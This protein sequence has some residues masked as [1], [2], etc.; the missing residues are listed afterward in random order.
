MQGI[1][2]SVGLIKRDNKTR[3]SI[4]NHADFPVWA[5][6]AI[7]LFDERGKDKNF[8]C[9]ILFSGIKNFPVFS[10]RGFE[11]PICELD[12]AI[13]SKKSFKAT[14]IYSCSGDANAAEKSN[15][16]HIDFIHDPELKDWR[17]QHIGMP[18]PLPYSVVNIPVAKEE[19]KEENTKKQK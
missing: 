19:K 7:K 16:T 2:L 18:Y 1:P 5:L 12:N 14:I 15:F 9:G 17:L 11:F 4:Y 13:K 6:I 3:I 8:K 10:K